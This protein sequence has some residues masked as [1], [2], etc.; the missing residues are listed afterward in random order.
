MNWSVIKFGVR[1][2]ELVEE[3]FD[4]EKVLEKQIR[5]FHQIAIK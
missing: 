3:L 2:R 5:L 1:S 4:E